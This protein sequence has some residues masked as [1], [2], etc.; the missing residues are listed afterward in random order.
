MEVKRYK[1]LVD[2]FYLFIAVPPAAIMLVISVISAIFEPM[3]LLVLVP[4]TAFVLCIVFSSPLFGYVELRADSVFIKF[5]LFLK[6]EIPYSS[7]KSAEL[8]RGW[9]SESMLSLKCA[10][11]HVNIKYN[12]FDVVTVSV[13]NNG[14][15]V[16]ELSFRLGGTLSSGQ[17]CD[18]HGT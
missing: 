7:I 18:A 15:F 12:T 17:P 3:S 16:R 10:L 6:K 8:C 11:G 13:V 14:E 5:G 4:T 1:P 9:Y 2:G